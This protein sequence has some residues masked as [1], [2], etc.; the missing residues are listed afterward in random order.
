MVLADKIESW[1]SKLEDVEAIDA[2]D[3]LKWWMVSSLHASLEG[4][5][6]WSDVNPD[7]GDILFYM[8]EQGQYTLIRDANGPVFSLSSD[9][10]QTL[11]RVAIEDGEESSAVFHTLQHLL[12]V[13]IDYET[14]IGHLV[15]SH[16]LT[17]VVELTSLDHDTILDRHKDLHRSGS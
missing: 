12:D 4:A 1:L 14:A 16:G 5:D 8:D 7:G 11:A 15:V 9:M 3:C 2:I 10:A 17:D 6:I 13:L